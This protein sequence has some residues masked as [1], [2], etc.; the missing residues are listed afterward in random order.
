MALPPAL[1]AVL[2]R[3]ETDGF[4]MGMAWEQ[5]HA[6]AQSREGEPMHD[7]LHALLHRIEGDEWNACYWY[8][9]AGQA[10]FQ[11]SFADEAAMLRGD[12]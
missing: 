4:A 2:A 6:L 7:R 3:L 12:G 5:A 1:A 10:P 9:R 8:R 11:G